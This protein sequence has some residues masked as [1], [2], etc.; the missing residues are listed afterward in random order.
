MLQETSDER[1][2]ALWELNAVFTVLQSEARVELVSGIKKMKK[3]NFN[4]HF[5]LLKPLTKI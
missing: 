2:T 3:N 4:K 1:R 5:L